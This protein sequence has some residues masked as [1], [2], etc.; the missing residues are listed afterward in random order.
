M[1]VVFIKR[2]RSSHLK[3]NMSLLE[4]LRFAQDDI[5]R[6]L[7]VITKQKGSSE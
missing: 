1:I 3:S 2:L 4:I 7:L 6:K 5:L